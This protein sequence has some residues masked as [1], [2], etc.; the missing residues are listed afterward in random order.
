MKNV[1]QFDYDYYSTAT[2]AEP[3]I[4]V[5]RQK[6]DIPYLIPVVG[7]PKDETVPLQP[8]LRRVT[9]NSMTLLSEK[10]WCSTDVDLLASQSS[11]HSVERTIT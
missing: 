7:M 8:N 5:E 2:N 3:N 6:E 11:N 10:H 4:L 1:K 9:D